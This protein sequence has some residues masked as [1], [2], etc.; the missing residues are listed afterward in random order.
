MQSYSPAPAGYHWVFTPRR[1]HRGA[2]RYLY[3]ADYGYE[4]WAFLVRNH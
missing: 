4:A 3:A 2:K 1:W